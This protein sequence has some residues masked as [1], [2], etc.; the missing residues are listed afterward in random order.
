MPAQTMSRLLHRFLRRTSSCCWGLRSLLAL[1][2]TDTAK[3]LMWVLVQARPFCL[4]AKFVSFAA[5]SAGQRPCDALR[6][7]ITAPVPMARCVFAERVH[8]C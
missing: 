7:L 2:I 4:S 1:S 8:S 6:G 3:V 5:R